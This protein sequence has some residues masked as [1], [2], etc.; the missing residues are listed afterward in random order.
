MRHN[1]FRYGAW[2]GGPDPLAPPY[3]VRAAVDQVEGFAP[4]GGLDH[5]ISALLEDAPRQIADAGFIIHGQDDGT[6][7]C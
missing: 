3:D 6:R 5:F 2:R 7:A 4:I 1:R